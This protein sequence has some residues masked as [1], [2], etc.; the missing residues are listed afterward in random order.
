M[1]KHDIP[2]IDLVCVNLYPF[3]RNRRQAGRTLDDAIENIDIGGPTMVR[4]A[5]KNYAP[6][7]HRHRPGRLRGAARRNAGQR[8]RAQPTPPASTWRR[9]PSPTPPLRRH[10]SNYLT[11]LNRRRAK[12]RS[13]LPDQPSTCSLRPR[14]DLPLRREPAPE[15]RLLRRRQRRRRQHRHLHASCRA[16]N[17]PTTTSPTPTPHWNA[18]SRS[19]PPRLRHRQ[20]RQPVRRGHRRHACWKPTNRAF[21]TDPTSAFGGIIAFNGEL[22]SDRGQAIVE[23]QF[24]EVHHRARPSAAEAKAAARR[25]EERAPARSCRSGRVP[26]T[27]W[28]FKRVGGGLLVQTPDDFTA[29]AETS[30][31]SPSAADRPGNGRPAVRLARRQVRQVQRHR[32]L[33]QTA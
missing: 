18:S 30:R 12:R 6:C 14:A 2:T 13:C 27:R 11:A 1:A 33:R 3:R 20:A 4:S 8:R 31:W 25:Q 28:T 5:A 26:S 9:R 17:C 10:I 24:V 23:R 7:R 22:D 16:R 19:T 29:Q 15:R 21:K 32:L